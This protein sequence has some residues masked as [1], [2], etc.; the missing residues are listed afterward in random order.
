MSD[1]IRN[2]KNDDYDAGVHAKVMIRPRVHRK[3]STMVCIRK[4]GDEEGVRIR[5]GVLVNI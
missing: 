5:V 2:A 1:P 4:S 3:P